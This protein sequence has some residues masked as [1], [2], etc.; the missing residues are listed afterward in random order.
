MQEGDTVVWEGHQV[1]DTTVQ[2]DTYIPLSYQPCVLCDIDP[3]LLMYH[4]P[5][6]A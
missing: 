6:G 4:C 2:S 3:L 5:L 1:Y